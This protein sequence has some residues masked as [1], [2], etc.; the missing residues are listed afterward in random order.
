[1][2]AKTH[3]FQK[4]P[5]GCPI[6][7]PVGIHQGKGHKILA[8]DAR[9]A[10]IIPLTAAQVSRGEV[11]RFIRKIRDNLLTTYL[12]GEKQVVQIEIQLQSLRAA[13]WE[14]H[15]EIQNLAADF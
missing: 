11:A 5:I 13:P 2:A 7:K 10:Q 3:I 6:A 4:I 8:G 15:P 12:H 14:L 9:R 1:M